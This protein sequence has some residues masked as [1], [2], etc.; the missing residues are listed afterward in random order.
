MASRTRSA[1]RFN[2][3]SGIIAQTDVSM[4]FVIKRR[5]GKCLGKLRVGQGVIR[6]IVFFGHLGSQLGIDFSQ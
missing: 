6:G 4:L 5:V 2:S 1:Q 3:A